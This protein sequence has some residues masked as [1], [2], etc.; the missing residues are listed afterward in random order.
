MYKAKDAGKN[1]AQFY[2]AEMTKDVVERVTLE[3]ELRIAIEKDEFVVYYQ[4]QINGSTGKLTGMEALV[5][6]HH[7]IHG[8]IPPCRF[9]QVAEDTGLIIPL[10]Q[11]VMSKAMKQLSSWYEKG[12]NPGILAINLA[13][14]QLQQID[15]ITILESIIEKSNCMPEWLELEVT[16]GQIM[17]NPEEAIEILKQISTLGIELAIDDFGTGYSSLSYLKRL[18]IDKLKIDRSFVKNLPYDDEDV[19][20]SCYRLIKKF[21]FKSDCRGCGD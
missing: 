11:L 3:H 4:P 18:P 2:S 21:K 9:I 6:W 1:I 19:S 15:F 20:K 12:L 7:P 8:L 14:Q 5:R 13:M 10:D 16:E 17:K